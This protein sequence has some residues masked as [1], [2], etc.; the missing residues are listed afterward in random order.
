MVHG[1]DPRVD[2]QLMCVYREM[3]FKLING[4][5]ETLMVL[6]AEGPAWQWLGLAT[7]LIMYGRLGRWKKRMTPT[8]LLEF[9]PFQFNLVHLW[10]SIVFVSTPFPMQ[11]ILVRLSRLMSIYSNCHFAKPISSHSDVYYSR[12]H[13]EKSYRCGSNALIKKLNKKQQTFCP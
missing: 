3:N 7:N 12:Q 2:L 8:K 11:P 13:R 4:W 6:T 1:P 9:H 5:T 10:F